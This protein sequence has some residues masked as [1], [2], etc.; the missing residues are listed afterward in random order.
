VNALSNQTPS[1]QRAGERRRTAQELAYDALRKAILRGELPEGA[2]LQQTALAK[3]LQVSTTPVREALGRLASD[4]L[5]RIDPHRGALV[6]GLNDDE[7][8]EIYELRQIIE[9][10]ATRKAAA[11]ITE[12]ELARAEH[13]WERMEDHGD[14]AEWAENNR[15]FHAIITA[16]AGAPHFTSILKGLRD[17][18]TR[19][20]Q[21]S[22]TVDPSRF[23][24]ANADHR[25]LIDALRSR[26]GDRAA[27]IEA[28][29]LH[30]TVGLLRTRDRTPTTSDVPPTT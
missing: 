27:A 29:H 13:L 17:S 6:R 23:T 10:V 2:R 16:A 28:R 1:L 20:V 24:A 11:R 7:L 30:A 14:A 3:Q 5:V 21:W 25:E 19:Y 4:G 8:E 26:D 15:Q 22:L 12:E 9:P 18:S